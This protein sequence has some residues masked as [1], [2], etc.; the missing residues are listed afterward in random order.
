M[1]TWLRQRRGI[2]SRVLQFALV[3]RR[4]SRVPAEL[5]ILW[6]VERFPRCP[7]ATENLLGVSADGRACITSEGRMT[8]IRHTGCARA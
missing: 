8:E 6:L 4:L 5:I 1:W 3:Y 7:Q 2:E